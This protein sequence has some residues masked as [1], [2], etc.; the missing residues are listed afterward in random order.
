M[1]RFFP[2]LLVLVLTACPSTGPVPWVPHGQIEL[3]ETPVA[4]PPDSLIECVNKVTADL[5]AALPLSA[6]LGVIKIS[7][8]DPNE[9]EFA[10]EQLIF[11]LVQAGKFR[12]V[13]RR[14]LDVIRTEQNFQLSGDVDDETAVSIGRMAGAGIVITGTIL[15]YGSDKHL[16]VRA[17]DVESSQIR[18][19]SSRPFIGDF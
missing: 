16:T 19:V 12:I 5:A 2:F 15:P 14:E 18:A 8:A 7:S 10:G 11:C 4:I 3:P 1:R 9:G 13:E 6:I 17:L